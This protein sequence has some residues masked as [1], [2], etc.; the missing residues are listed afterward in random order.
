MGLVIYYFFQSVISLFLFIVFFL[1]LKKIVFLI[2]CAKLG[3]FPFFYWIVVVRLKVNYLRN[4]FI[5]GLQKVPVFWFLWLVYDSLLLL[6]L[7]LV[8]FSIFFVL[9]NLLLISDLWLLLVYSSIA[10]TGLLLFSIYGSYYLLSIF[11]Y[12]S[13]VIFIIF[14]IKFLDRYSNI[15]FVVLIFIVVPPF[16]LFFIKIFVVFRVLFSL[17][18]VLFLFFLDVFILFYYFTL[19]FIKFLLFEGRV[20]IYFLNFLLLLMILLFRNCVTL[21]VF[22]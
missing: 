20:L 21:I 13:I 12:L 9:I 8:Y 7:L 19:I 15:L 2:L 14:C 22:Y 10:N 17:K 11:I 16:F 5:L 3:L 6:I 4:I 18:L 1:S